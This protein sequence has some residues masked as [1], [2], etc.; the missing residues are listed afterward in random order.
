MPK[1]I[2]APAILGVVFSLGA[3]CSAADQMFEL[4]RYENQFT[5]VRVGPA[6]MAD[7]PG[8]AVVFEGT[9][10]LHYYAKKRPPPEDSI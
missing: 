5:S 7:K 4:A 2:I 6:R 10:D 9:D 3:L 1:Q 8:I